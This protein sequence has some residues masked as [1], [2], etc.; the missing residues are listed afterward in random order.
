MFLLL[1]LELWEL[2]TAVQIREDP[3]VMNMIR[4]ARPEDYEA[5]ANLLV[6]EGM[7][8]EEFF[9]RERF[10]RGIKSFGR[11]YLVEERDG[12][13]VGF[14]SG[15]DDGGIFYGYMGRLVVHPDCRRRG[16]G[17]ALTMEC[18]RRFRKS[19]IPV[20]YTGA[21]L[22]N[23]PSQNLL[24]KLGFVDEGYKLLYLDTGAVNKR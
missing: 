23:K 10:V 20:V 3:W 7:T 19:G 24:M 22:R 1:A 6:S 14:I 2:Q 5:V 17:N 4:N 15:F 21:A 16:V 13:V 18:L 11:Y 9:T 8:D 12:K